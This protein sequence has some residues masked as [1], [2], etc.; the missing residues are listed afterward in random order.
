MKAILALLSLVAIST[1]LAETVTIVATAPVGAVG[2]S[3]PFTIQSNHV[4][5]TV[6]AFVPPDSDRLSGERYPF[7]TVRIGTN[8]FV[9]P[10]NVPLTVAGPAVIKLTLD[11]TNP[12]FETPVSSYLT[13]RVSDEQSQFTPSTAVVIPSDATGPVRIILESSADLLNWADALPGTYGG[14]TTNRFFRV[15]AVKL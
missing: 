9:S 6:A 8:D 4:A 11:N 10:G 3:P 2:T 5:T 12:F 1:A 15:R 13:L 14:A 7:V